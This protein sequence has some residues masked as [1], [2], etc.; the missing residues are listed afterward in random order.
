MITVWK[1]SKESFERFMSRFDHA[2]QRSRVVRVL[3]EK[4]YRKK[5]ATRRVRREAALK[6][7]EYR[8]R[9]EKM[10]FY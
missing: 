2:V 8:S 6:R 1:N 5:E 10:K 4:R 3:R 7:T 9:R